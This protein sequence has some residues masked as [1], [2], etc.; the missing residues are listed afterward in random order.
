MGIGSDAYPEKLIWP[1]TL[2][3]VTAR[4]SNIQ[5]PIQNLVGLSTLTEENVDEGIQHVINHYRAEKK[6]FGWLVGPTSQPANLRDRL[7]AAG[8]TEMKEEGM[9]GMVLK[10]TNTPI[11]T[12]PDIRVKRVSIA[13][14][15]M[16]IAMLVEAYGFGMSEEVANSLN[17]VYESMG[18]LCQVYFAYVPE[19]EEPVA[20]AASIFDRGRSVLTLGG[21]ATLKAYRG[22]GIYATMVA[23]RL[24]DA[25]AMGITCAIIQAIKTTSAPICAKLGFEIVCPIDHYAYLASG[26]E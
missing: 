11:L 2:P 4:S 9:W 5:S 21:A 15:N 18:E 17:R 16:N 24:E 22:R 3:G 7:V 1:V 25:R 10:N 12:N 23:K 19:R 26:Q 14:W 6:I 8:F 20:F 13:D